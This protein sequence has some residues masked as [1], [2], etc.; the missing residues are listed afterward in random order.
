MEGRMSKYRQV[1]PERARVWTEKSGKFVQNRKV[2]VVY[3]LSRNRQLE[4]PH[5]IEVP[6]S[7]SQG[8]YLRDVIEK[9]N[10]LRGRGMA[11]MYSWSCKRSYKN[12]FVWHDLCEDDLIIP[13]QGNEYVLKGSEVIEESNSDHLNPTATPRIQN[14][15][16]LQ[17]PPSSTC[18]DETSSSS[19]MNSKDIKHQEDEISPPSR[20]SDSSGVSLESRTETS[21]SWVG[22]LS[23]TE[24]KESKN[25]GVADAS[26]Q[27]DKG[28]RK[29]VLTETCIHGE[30]TYDSPIETRCT[31]NCHNHASKLC[32]NSLSPPSSSSASSSGVKT[33]TLESL[34]RI[35]ASKTNNFRRLKEEDVKIP[36]NPMLKASNMLMQLISCGSMS[37]KDHNFGLAPAYRQQFSHLKFP[38]SLYSTSVMLGELDCLSENPRLMRLKLEDKEYFSG[39]LAEAK[40]LKEEGSS[41][42]SLKR[43]S[44]FNADRS[45]SQ[46]ELN[47]NEETISARSSCLPLS[48]KASEG[49][50]PRSESMRFPTSEKPKISSSS[51]DKKIAIPRDAPNG[52]SGRITA[53]SSLENRVFNGSCSMR[54]EK[55]KIIKI[56]ES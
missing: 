11:S 13:A 45:C 48:I 15:K 23:Y 40:S 9:L 16:Q 10:V 55:G 25:G 6:L 53:P 34:I 19:S 46:L 39:S 29:S 52:D 7:S 54:E 2:P 20:S 22:S 44:S 31:G 21:S 38:S 36:P 12:G 42:S 33:G 24:Y 27:T 35:D 49:K 28:T 32:R 1:S 14:V 18:Q 26:T 3:Y 30:S 17:E 43:S 56:E 4:H 8:L 5:F 47:A 41:H 50:Q 37:V 51:H